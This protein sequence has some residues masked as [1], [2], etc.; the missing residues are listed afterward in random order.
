[1]GKKKG[2]RWG[3][4]WGKVASGGRMF[5]V[6]GGITLAGWFAGRIIPWALVLAIVG[7]FTMLNGLMGDEGVW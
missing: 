2:F 7:L 3:F 5:L 1:M 6:G 4:Q